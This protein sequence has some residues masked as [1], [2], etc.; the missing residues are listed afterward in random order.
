MA[1]TA[2]AAATATATAS[3]RRRVVVELIRFF[4]HVN[5]A[6]ALIA[7]VV[8][9]IVQI[10]LRSIGP[11]STS[12]GSSSSVIVSI[13]LFLQTKTHQKTVYKADI[14][15]GL[16]VIVRLLRLGVIIAATAAKRLTYRAFDFVAR[17]LVV[18]EVRNNTARP[19]LA[20]AAHGQ[21]KLFFFRINISQAVRL[22]RHRCF[23]RNRSQRHKAPAIPKR[24]DLFRHIAAIHNKA[25]LNV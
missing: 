4:R 3:T 2:T 12:D 16:V 6:V 19:R 10:L 18:Q 8:S 7:D 1:T 13:S 14:V 17:R 22:T 25:P 9:I 23:H 24:L 15:A 21:Q 11:L 5:R 20:C